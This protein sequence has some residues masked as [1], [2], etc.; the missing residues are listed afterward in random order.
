M[1]ADS[2][3]VRKHELLCSNENR[4]ASVVN[5]SNEN[6]MTSDVNGSV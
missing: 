6:R 4:M 1:C 3:H 2:W 5:G